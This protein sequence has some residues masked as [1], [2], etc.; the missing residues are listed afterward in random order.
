MLAILPEQPTYVSLI[1][2]DG[3]EDTRLRDALRRLE[4]FTLPGKR[5]VYVNVHGTTLRRALGTRDKR[6]YC[7]DLHVLA[8]IV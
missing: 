4:A 5:G 2:V 6:I 7:F 8:A 1:D 3:Q